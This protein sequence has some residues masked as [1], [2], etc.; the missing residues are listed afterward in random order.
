[1]KYA[2]ISDIHANLEAFTAVLG[3]I[4][5]RDVAKIWCLGDVIDYGPNPREC[6]KLMQRQRQVSVAGNHD[7]AALNM[8]STADFH[9]DAAAANDW[10]RTQLQQG[11]M[12]FLATLPSDIVEGDCYLVHGSPREPIWEYL[13]S[14]D[15]ARANLN[16]FKSNFCLIGHTHKPAI[17][18][19][20]AG[21]VCTVS[22]FTE[23]TEVVL[24]EGRFF[25]NPGAVGQPRDGDP[26]ASYAIY[27]S[28]AKTVRLVRVSYDVAATQTKML[29][30]GLPTNLI[31]R[32]SYGL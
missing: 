5:K 8:I 28:E 23:D 22:E 15:T 18:R 10:T 4:S 27:D 9:P 13:T 12:D 6:I 30:A 26:R 2:I 16:Y 14:P 3:D 32:L 25:V 31:A 21:D 19:C 7:L 20:E 1:M 11:D 17:I 24:Q 29:Q